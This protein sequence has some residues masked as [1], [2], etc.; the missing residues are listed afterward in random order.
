MGEI[1]VGIIGTGFMGECHALAFTS[2]T[3]LFQPKLRPRLAVVADVNAAA[4]ERARDRFGFGR[5]TADWRELVS[6]PEFWI[7][8]ALMHFNDLIEWRYDAQQQGAD[9]RNYGVG[10][11][12]E[13][14]LY[15]LWLRAELGYDES[16]SDRYLLVRRG[17]IA[18]E[19][20]RA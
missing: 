9:S 3:P 12:G 17:D 14:F 16:S 15:R 10:A 20:A 8:L 13:T 7:W 1:G 19:P 18:E 6:D 4:A 2:V 11:A 5:A